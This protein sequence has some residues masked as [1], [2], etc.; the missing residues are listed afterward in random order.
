MEDASFE[1]GVGEPTSVVLYTSPARESHALNAAAATG[2][3]A[4]EVRL[5]NGQAM[6]VMGAA[7]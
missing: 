2:G 4:A 3:T 6:I 1:A 7:P 5:I